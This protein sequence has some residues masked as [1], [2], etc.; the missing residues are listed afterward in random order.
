MDLYVAGFLREE[1]AVEINDTN[2]EAFAFLLS[3]NVE[4]YEEI[5]DI[6]DAVKIKHLALLYKGEV[7][8]YYKDQTDYRFFLKMM[9][10]IH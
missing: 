1:K 9:L 8:I 6:A 2:R 3:E 4:G 10:A 5:P 7:T